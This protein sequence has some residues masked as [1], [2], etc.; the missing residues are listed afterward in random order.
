MEEL[1]KKAR[2][3][4][5]SGAV[6]V[7]IG[8][9]KGSGPKARAIFVRK[10]EQTDQLIFNDQCLQNLAVYLTKPEVK[11][12][13][14]PA[15]VAKIPALR[16]ILQLAA[17]NQLKDEDLLAL[18]IS[19]EGKLVELASLKAIEDFLAG[20][21]LELTGEEKSLLE[22]IEKMSPE[23]RWNFWQDQFKK[24]VKC[25]ACRA[26]CPMCYCERCLCECNQPQW[27]PVASHQIGNLDWH[28]IRA[29][30]LASRCVNCGDCARACPVGIPLNL[31]NQKLAEEVFKQ[32]SARA[33]MKAA[34]EYAL[35][36]WKLEDKENFIR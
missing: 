18:G 33:G 12:L 13:G 32:F 27:V 16:A 20:L 23:E 9:G 15:I 1:R 3:L 14:K 29:M 25:Y 5:T 17:E 7:I 19:P 24:C 6:K 4:L 28:I 36:N 30:H 11:A 2:E 26:S 22:K 10:P 31:L 21:S 8:Y 35:C 34:Q